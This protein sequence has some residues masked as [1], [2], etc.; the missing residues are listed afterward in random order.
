MTC[1]LHALKCLVFELCYTNKM[2]R[3][4]NNVSHDWEFQLSV[5][6]SV[7]TFCF[8]CASAS[9]KFKNFHHG[10]RFSWVN[11]GKHFSGDG[12]ILKQSQGVYVWQLPHVCVRV[13]VGEHTLDLT[14][15]YLCVCEWVDY[16]PN[17]TAPSLPSPEERGAWKWK[18]CIKEDLAQPS[19]SS[20][21]GIH[22]P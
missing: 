8:F 17:P 11:Y 9:K 1:C 20:I 6:T 21:L 3:L 12:S 13:C 2:P 19:H 4:A 22:G 16:S 18:S 15:L 10:D 5:F 14:D 7:C